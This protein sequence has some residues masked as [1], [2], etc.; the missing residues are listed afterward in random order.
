MF[1]LLEMSMP[2]RILL[3][4]DYCEKKELHCTLTKG[5]TA[6]QVVVCEKVHQEALKSKTTK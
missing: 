2:K 1:E 6:S 5:I 4:R 3:G